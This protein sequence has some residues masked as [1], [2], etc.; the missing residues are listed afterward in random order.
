MTDSYVELK[1]T[2]GSATVLS[3]VWRI[4]PRNGGRSLFLLCPYCNTPRRHVYGW[5]WDSF[6]RM[7]KQSQANQLEAPVLCSAALF[8]RGRLLASNRSW[9][10]W[11]HAS[12]FRKPTNARSLGFLLSLRPS[13]IPVSTRSLVRIAPK[14]ENDNP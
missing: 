8:F 3:I 5:E 7:V 1:R 11:D 2:D 13:M 9:A 14:S 10:T 4:L 12:R 6:F